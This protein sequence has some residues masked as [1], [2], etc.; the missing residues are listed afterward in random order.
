MISVT[1]IFYL[2]K[3][4]QQFIKGGDNYIYTLIVTFQLSIILL[5]LIEF[6]WAITQQ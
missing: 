3:L 6:A 1:N 2:I 4:Y 5:E